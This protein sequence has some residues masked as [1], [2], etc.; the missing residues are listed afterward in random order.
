MLDRLRQREVA[1][2]ERDAVSRGLEVGR[3]VVCDGHA[4]VLA[5][6]ATDG[7]RE[8][9]LALGHVAG[10]RHVQQLAPGLDEGLRGGV[11]H[12]EVA[13]LLVV[14]GEGAHLGVVEGVGQEA[15]VDHEVGL[16]RHAVLEAEREH[17]HVEQL[18]VRE[19]RERV[20][21]A[22]A[23]GGRP[24]VA[25]VDHL[26]GPV[27]HGRELDA[28]ARDGALQGLAGVRD[29]VATARLLVAAHEDLVRAVE[30][31]HLD[32][33]LVLAQ[34]TDGV[35]QLVEQP[36]APEVA[37]DGQVAPHARVD[38]HDVGKVEHQARGQVVDA[39]VAHVLE[40]VHGLR[41]AAAR[42][43]R[44]DHDVRDAIAFS[45]GAHDLSG[46]CHDGLLSNVGPV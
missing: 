27:A 30:E 17:A 29:G 12:H 2:R 26:V 46:V 6:R 44:D 13:H 10:H 18:L 33:E 40:H 32:R 5:A 4:A 3:R 23:Q 36:L 43:A 11:F 42:H 14:A 15:H 1:V 28:L 25:G 16:G 8:L 38:A 45:R 19:L 21:D 22:A 9:G 37:R 41:A 7:D 39:V 35:V 24:E 34:L 20:L 31:Q